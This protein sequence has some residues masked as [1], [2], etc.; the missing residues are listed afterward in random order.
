LAEESGVG[1]STLL[2]RKR[3]AVQHLRARL[4][5]IYDEFKL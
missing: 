2:A 3:Y 4:Q 5:L 1:M